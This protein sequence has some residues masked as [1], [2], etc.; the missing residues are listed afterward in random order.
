LGKGVPD[1]VVMV[2]RHRA[3]FKRRKILFVDEAGVVEEAIPVPDD[4]L[5]CDA[6]GDP[7]TTDSVMLLVLD[8]SIWGAMC[9]KCR[10]KYHRDKPLLAWGELFG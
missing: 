3:M 10:L 9:E 8:E 2:S 1:C 4:V 5:V 6:C 7:I